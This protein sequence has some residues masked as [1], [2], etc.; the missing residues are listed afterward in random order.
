MYFNETSWTDWGQGK[1]KSP[2]I[3]NPGKD[4]LK[5]LGGG[6]RGA[7]D[8][9][10]NTGRMPVP[11]ILLKIVVEKHRQ[12]ACSTNTSQNSCGKKNTGRMPVPQILLKILVASCLFL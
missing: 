8:R 3:S 10:K 12:D 2:L 5:N 7:S 4:S 11:Q 9:K 1:G 6:G